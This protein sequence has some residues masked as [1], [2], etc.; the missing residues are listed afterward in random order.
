MKTKVKWLIGILIVALLV[1]AARSS[2]LSPRAQ[3][4]GP[5]YVAPDGDDGADC[6]STTTPCATI[7]GAIGKAGSGDTIYVAVGTYTGS[8][9]E[10]VLISKSVTLSGGWDSDFSTKSD[11]SIIDGEGSRQGIRVESSVTAVI[12]HFELQNGYANSGYGSGGGGGI[13]NFG[14]LTLNSTTVSG[15]TAVGAFSVGGGIINEG[16]LTLNDSTVSDNAAENEGG[17]IFNNGL[18][19]LNSSTVSRNTARYSGGGIFAHGSM[20]LNSSTV[21]DNISDG[22]GGGIVNNGSV[23]LN[24]STISGNRSTSHGA[25]GGGILNDGTLTLSNS[26][27]SGNTTGHVNGGGGVRNGYGA[28]ASQNSILAG[29]AA[30]GISSDC[31][32]SAITSLGHN[33]IGNTSGCTFTS[34][35]GDLIN[36]EPKLGSLEGSPGFHPLLHGSPAIDAGNPSGCTDDLGDPL[37]TDQRGRPRLGRCD[38]GAYEAQALETSNKTVDRTFAMPGSSLNYAIAL[39]NIGDAGVE[40]VIMTDTIPG[41]LTYH[42]GS[43]DS[44]SAT[45]DEADGTITCLASLNA[46]ASLTVTYGATL[47][48]APVGTSVV[49]SAVISA[50]GEIITRTATLRVGEVRVCNLTKYQFNPVLQ[51]ADDGGWDSDDVW[52]PTVLKEGIHYNMWYSGDDGSG[53]SQIGLATSTDGVNWEKEPN[54]PVLSPGAPWESAGL[55]AASVI[56]DGGAYMMWYTGFDSNG[57]GRI[58]CATSV[59]GVT[60]TRCSGNPV[61]VPGAAGGWE[62][63]GV[64]EPTV[65]KEGGTYHMWYVGSDRITPRIGHATSSDGVNWIKDPANPALDIGPLGDWDWLQVYG[66]E[67]VA[68]SGSYLLWYS[69]GTLPRAWQTGYATSH[70]GSDWLR[71]GV[72]IP[73]GDPEGD[74]PFDTDSADFP[75]VI[76]DSNRFKVWY[77]GVAGEDSSI[78]F[79]TAE[80][81]GL[82]ARVEPPV[83]N[84]IYL[85]IVVKDWST[86]PCPFY[87]ADDFGDHRSGW[88]ITEDETHAFAYTDGEYQISIRQPNQGWFVT[89]GALATDFSLEVSARRTDGTYGAYGVI[90]GLNEDWG[91]LY[92]FDVDDR[93]YSIWKLDHGAWTILRD[94][95]ASN[96]IKTGTSWNRLRV[97]REGVEI[98]V[99]VNDQHLATVSDGRFVGLRRIGLYAASFRAFDARFDDF[100]LYPAD[101]PASCGRGAANLEAEQW[102]ALTAQYQPSPSSGTRPMTRYLGWNSD[103][104]STD[105]K[106]AGDHLWLRDRRGLHWRKR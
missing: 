95:T 50:A 46:G 106:E 83:L 91:E 30:S 74:A 47:E 66:P 87:Y 4:A 17:G 73:E 8:G 54:N 33:L 9:D 10:V 59:D 96:Y 6:L 27:I 19:T 105:M 71:Q 67:I 99:Y 53:P 70:S 28:V 5:W 12:E 32:G 45:C 20:T 56:L 37:A 22:S 86:Q 76:V 77:T 3:A 41:W 58:G 81:C 82:G 92:G 16:T 85:P 72:I 62:D 55:A 98:A 35:S 78:G 36:V 25:F 65:T 43:L 80:I 26:T 60:W 61:L 31:S 94:W 14:T 29:N 100:A 90:F 48:E 79:A 34:T 64:M 88:P 42:A 97:V 18:L 69:G 68:Y 11:T 93:Y 23:S 2:S 89:P 103:G 101:Y 75:T 102:L 49:N 13:V 44:N 84:A 15:N 38:I 104:Y 39:R 21:R 52:A 24:N 40:D 57:V 51:T 63:A 7:N 1:P